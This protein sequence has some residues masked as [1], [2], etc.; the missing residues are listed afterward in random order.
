[1][2]TVNVEV[3]GLWT[4]PTVT[5][6][7]P[8]VA[9][10][11]AV[12]IICVLVQLAIVEAFVPL[13]LTVLVP[14]EPPKLEPAIVT[15]VP[16]PPKSGEMPVTKGVEPTVIDTL[17]KVPVAELVRLPLVTAR[18][19]RTFVPMLIVWLDPNCVHVEPSGEV[20]P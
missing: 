3:D 16:V 8:V 2:M 13:K 6:T 10:L 9:P 4:P 7:S 5:L 19:M 15:D 12:A 14:C 20:Y 11:G 1:M 18:P 17:S